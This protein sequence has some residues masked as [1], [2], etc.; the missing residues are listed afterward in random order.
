M[1]A[2]ATRYAANICAR[3]PRRPVVTNRPVLYCHENGGG[4]GSIAAQAAYW[5]VIPDR[6]RTVLAA[7]DLGSAT[8]WGNDAALTALTA[9]KATVAGAG[10]WSQARDSKVVLFGGSMGTVTALN[11]ARANPTLVAAIVIGLPVVDAEDVRANNRGALQAPIEAA[12]TN[13]AGWQSA[14]ATHNPIEY[15]A[16]LSAIPMK[17]WYASDDTIALPANV[18][19]FQA[20][21]GASCEV[22]SM[23]A[24]GHTFA[25]AMLAEEIAAYLAAYV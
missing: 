7:H 6:L 15:A 24:V 2:T 5:E 20:L 16:S 19:S 13:N 25:Y 8:N 1:V 4:A 21:V 12:Y 14:R 11:W 23:G 18:L 3:L 9:F 10:Y 17:L 22:Q